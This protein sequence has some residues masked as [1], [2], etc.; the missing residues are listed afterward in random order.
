M[1]ADRFGGS[2]DVA[3]VDIDDTQVE[4]VR[5][6]IDGRDLE[7]A[8]IDYWRLADLG[9]LDHALQGVETLG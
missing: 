3:A 1:N 7:R 9:A 4:L 6:L 5:D 8:D 2:R